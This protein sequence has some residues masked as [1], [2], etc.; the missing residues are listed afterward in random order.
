MKDNSTEIIEDHFFDEMVDGNLINYFHIST[1][2]DDDLVY[3]NAFSSFVLAPDDE[4]INIQFKFDIEELLI[5][6]IWAKEHGEGSKIISMEDKPS[7]DDLRR[8]CKAMIGCIN[9]LEFVD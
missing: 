4:D 2:C 8:K 9:S 5:C 6:M 1:Q 7:F 3:H